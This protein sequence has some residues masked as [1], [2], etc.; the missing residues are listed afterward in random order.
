[1][2][3]FISGTRGSGKWVIGVVLMIAG[4]VLQGGLAPAADEPPPGAIRF[5]G[6]TVIG[7]SEGEFRR[8]HI[9][10]AVIDE[11]H[12]E[13]SSVAVVI[14]LTSVD[15]GNDTR[16]RHLRSADFLDVDHYPTA[17]VRLHA[18]EV[19][20]SQHFAA[21]VELDLH[22]RSQSFPMRFA[23][24]DREAR[25]IAGEITL[26]RS[27]FGVGAT[28]GFFNPFRVDDEVHVMIEA[29]VPASQDSRVSVPSQHTREMTCPPCSGRLG[30]NPR[31]PE[32]T[33]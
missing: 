24:V 9:T 6:H 22:G 1:M 15:T 32:S 10:D 33:C 20:D 28:N 30:I 29:V 12:P 25:R 16:D 31:P 7:T 19:E 21:T 8:W 26:K 23:I 11:E 13:R 14:D 3:Q 27:E 4:A 17:T 2:S 5:R 18:I